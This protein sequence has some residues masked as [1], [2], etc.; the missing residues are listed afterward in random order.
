MAHYTIRLM[1]GKGKVIG[2]HGPLHHTLNGWE[3]QI[4]ENNVAIFTIRKMVE[5]VTSAIKLVTEDGN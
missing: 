3:G 4:Q 5:R 2:V 1:V